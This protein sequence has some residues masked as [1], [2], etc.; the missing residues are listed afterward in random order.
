M[1]SW[2]GPTTRRIAA[3]TT[4]TN[5]SLPKSSPE[6]LRLMTSSWSEIMAWAAR[7]VNGPSFYTA[8][9]TC[10]A[11]NSCILRLRSQRPG[12]YP[13]C[14]TCCMGPCARCGPLL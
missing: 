1:R 7:A 13:G 3:Q 5:S 6:P 8:V 12:K 14:T 9:L 4:T 10:H 2:K 11:P